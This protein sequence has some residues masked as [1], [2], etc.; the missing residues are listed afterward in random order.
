MNTSSKGTALITGA[1]SG[2]GAIYADR[3]ARRGHD[4]ILVARNRE[5][6]DALATRITNDTGRSVAVIVADLNASEDLARVEQA[7]R[8]DPSITALVNNAGI[9]VPVP[10]L[11]TDIDKLA[12]MIDLNVTALVRLTYAVMPPFIKRGNGAIIN[13]G[14]AVGIA[15]ELLN[16]VYGGTKA[17]V[18][19]FSLSL[20]KEFAERN[21]RVQAVIPGATATDFW[22][23]A[24]T[25]LERL[26]S[27]VVMKAEDLVDAAIA[28]FDLGEL[29]TIPSLPDIADWETYETARQRMIPM[30][31]LSF[32][33]ARYGVTALKPNGGRARK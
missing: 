23:I 4:L 5:R 27:E 7:L 15:P 12:R 19:A 8:T 20:H 31:S 29:V 21:I 18:L 13:I 32:P 2:I 10:L 3:L 25:P 11:D 28:G 9:G 6:L 30:L 17:F 14:S 33:A 26:P 22:D 24:E 16:G 1:S